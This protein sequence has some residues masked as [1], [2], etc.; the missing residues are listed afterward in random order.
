MLNMTCCNN[1]NMNIDSV[2]YVFS[3]EFLK[4]YMKEH[5]QFLLEISKNDD[6]IYSI[7]EF[8]DSLEKLCFQ[9]CVKC[10]SLAVYNQKYRLDY[11][12]VNDFSHVKFEQISNWEDYIAIPR[13]EISKF[14]EFSIEKNP[15]CVI[16]TFSAKIRYKKSPVNDCLYGYDGKNIVSQF[17]LA[18][19]TEIVKNGNTTINRVYTIEN[20][21]ENLLRRYFNCHV[22]LVLKNGDTFSGIVK[23]VDFGEDYFNRFK[24]YVSFLT[25]EDI[26][27]QFEEK[28]IETI[29]WGCNTEINELIVLARQILARKYWLWDNGCFTVQNE[30]SFVVNVLSEDKKIRIDQCDDLGCK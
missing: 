26:F 12:S 14:M 9:N 29:I 7:M 8:D 21:V 25:D 30:K 23:S 3:V 19:Y 28:D 11:V 20:G 2:V 24:Y 17:I 22:N 10:G 15:L 13:N 18:F 27:L 16:E 5:P 4:E 1:H 6:C